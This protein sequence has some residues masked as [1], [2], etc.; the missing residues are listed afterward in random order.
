[1]RGAVDL[2]AKFDNMNCAVRAQFGAIVSPKAGFKGISGH[3]LVFKLSQ[4][5][6]VAECSK[7]RRICF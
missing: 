2:R 1:M 4:G 6:G 7:R 5:K 3:D